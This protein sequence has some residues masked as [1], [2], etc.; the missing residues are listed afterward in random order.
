MAWLTKKGKSGYVMKLDKDGDNYNAV[1]EVPNGNYLAFAKQNNK[2]TLS[3]S[4]QLYTSR[5]ML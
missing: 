5:N 2:Y 1:I 3:V 4:E